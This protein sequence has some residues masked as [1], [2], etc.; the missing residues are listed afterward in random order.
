MQLQNDNLFVISGTTAGQ[1]FSNFNKVIGYI[2]YSGTTL[3]GDL[4]LISLL[5]DP[6]TIQ[7]K[8][9]S[10]DGTVVDNSLAVGGSVSSPYSLSVGLDNTV[11][12]GLKGSAIIGGSGN[13]VLSDNIIILGRTGLA[14]FESDSTYANFLRATGLDI[15]STRD[16][17]IHTSADTTITSESNLYLHGANFGASISLGTLDNPTIMIVASSITI[18]GKFEYITEPVLVDRTEIVHLG[19]LQDSINSATS[20]LTIASSGVSLSEEVISTLTV[21]SITAGDVFP[22]G[23]SFTDFVKALLLQTFYPTFVNPTFSFTNNVGV[24]EIGSDISFTLTYTFGRGQILGDLTPTWDAL[25]VQD[26][27]AGIATGYTIDSIN[28]VGNSLVKSAYTVLTTQTFNGTV[29]YAEGPQPLDSEGNNYSS[30]LAASS[31]TLSTSFSGIY[32]YF[33]LKS[34]SPISAIGMQTAI[35][36]GTATKVVASSTGTITVDYDANGEYI[37]IAYPASNTT[38]TVWYVTALDNGFIP[39]G[40]VGGQTTLSC[41]SPDTY[42]TGINYKI[43]VSAGLITQSQPIQFRN[44]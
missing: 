19:Y 43:H 18:D 31:V 17:F 1:L 13:T 10:I 37:A 21:G 30:P 7:F 42:W 2:P 15:Q 26:F 8:S 25:A 12:A 11:T 34:S 41:D 28:Q 35:Q 33:Y 5:G 14:A 16:I 23:T 4:S 32:P 29:Y 9:L 44:S 36:N 39:G 40:L 24:V 22:V 6:F 20:G 27:R 3:N 38:K